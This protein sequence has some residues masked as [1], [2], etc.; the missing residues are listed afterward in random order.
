[1]KPVAASRQRPGPVRPKGRLPVVRSGTPAECPGAVITMHLQAGACS[2]LRAGNGPAPNH[3][4][5]PKMM[6]YGRQAISEVWCAARQRSAAYARQQKSAG[7]Q[8]ASASRRSTD[9]GGGR[10]NGPRQVP[11]RPPTECFQ[12]PRRL[13]VV[14]VW[15]N[16]GGGGC[17]RC[18]RV[19]GRFWEQPPKGVLP[20]F[21]PETPANFR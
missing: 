1:M 6:L 3:D 18:G 20:L 16:E 21:L 17:T 14:V 12:Q 19:A 7:E 5:T 10:Q 11:S 15:W 4:G 13:V 2:S 8:A 9:P